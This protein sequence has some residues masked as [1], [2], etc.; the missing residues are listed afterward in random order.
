LTAIKKVLSLWY[1]YSNALKKMTNKSTITN[2]TG[3]KKVNITYKQENYKPVFAQYIQVINT[4]IGGIDEHVLQSK[5][6]STL[7]GARK[8]AKNT[9]GL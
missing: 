9:L 5:S 6:F 1:N 8:W 3:S 4:E 7:D 2:T